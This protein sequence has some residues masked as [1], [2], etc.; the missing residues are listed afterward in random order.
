MNIFISKQNIFGNNNIPANAGIQI[1]QGTYPIF[2][3]PYQ[4]Q[5]VI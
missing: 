4:T 1:I 3:I 5:N 2:R